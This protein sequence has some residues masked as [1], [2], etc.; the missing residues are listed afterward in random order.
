MGCPK[1]NRPMASGA[2]SARHNRP[3][4]Q[5]F[6]RHQKIDRDVDESPGLSIDVLALPSPTFLDG[7]LEIVFLAV[8][9]RVMVVSFGRRGGIR[10]H[11]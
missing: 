11:R 5:R 1:C 6:L 4:K 9:A 7:N 3:G 10:R 2:A 8:S